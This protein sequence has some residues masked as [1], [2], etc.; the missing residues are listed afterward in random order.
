MET[1]GKGF[2]WGKP[3]GSFRDTEAPFPAGRGN[4]LPGGEVTVPA[5]TWPLG[6]AGC[7]LRGAVFAEGRGGAFSI[8]PILPKGQDTSRSGKRWGDSRGGQRPSAAPAAAPERTAPSPT[9][10]EGT[11]GTPRG[12]RGADGSRG[13]ARVLPTR[14]GSRSAGPARSQGRGRRSLRVPRQRGRIGTRNNFMDVE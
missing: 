10:A 8:S 9:C 3:G 1:A 5:G 7:E 2:G 13:P 12:L 6:S 11:L 4:A 14:F